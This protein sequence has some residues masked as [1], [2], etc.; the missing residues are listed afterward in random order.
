MKQ[1]KYIRDWVEE[2]PKLGKLSFTIDDVNGQFPVMGKS[3]VKSALHRLIADDKIRNIRKGFYSIVLPEYG[4]KGNI[5]PTE[6]VDQLFS[7]IGADYY[8]A[9]LSAAALQGASHQAA[10]VF[11]VMSTKQLR[12]IHKGGMPI[13]FSHK[14]EIASEY[15]ESRTVNSGEIKV[16]RPELTAFDLI[17]YRHISGGL[18]HVATVLSELAEEM[19]F[20]NMPEHL[21]DGVSTSQIQ[22]L[23]YILDEVVEQSD[24]ADSLYEKA[25]VAGIK[26]RKMPL[27]HTQAVT[28]DISRYIPKWKIVENTELGA[29]L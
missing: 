5:P 22:L 15:L 3:S 8:V 24:L 19:D 1:Y 12:P 18:Q 16:S 7:Y 17:A 10:Q 14:R 9:L 29:D 20:D 21:L 27:A 6:Y 23:G 13:I 11:Q 4:I 25:K 2:M 28:D 26:F